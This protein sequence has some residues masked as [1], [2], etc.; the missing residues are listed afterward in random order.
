MRDL[1]FFFKVRSKRRRE[2][3]LGLLAAARVRGLWGRGSEGEILG[4]RVGIQ[5][6]HKY[7][8]YTL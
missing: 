6:I 3:G 5:N 4:V 7:I 2:S 8:Y 1:I